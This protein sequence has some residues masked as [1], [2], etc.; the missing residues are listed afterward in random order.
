[1]V[2][3][4]SDGEKKMIDKIKINNE[5]IEPDESGIADISPVVREHQS[6]SQCVMRTEIRVVTQSQWDVI[7]DEAEDGVFYFVIEG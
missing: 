7:K 2:G 5:I 4:I 3:V 1:M 6:L